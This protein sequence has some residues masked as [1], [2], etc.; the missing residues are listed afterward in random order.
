MPF[1]YCGC[2]TTYYGCKDVGPDGSYVTT[3]WFVLWYVPLIP[4][5]SY[6]VLPTKNST[7]LLVYQSQKYLVG[8]IPL[9]RRQVLNGYLA[10]GVIIAAIALIWA[11]F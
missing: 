3:E 5:R 8:K 10:T 4:L 2:G 11:L 1:T 6:R 9:D 7:N